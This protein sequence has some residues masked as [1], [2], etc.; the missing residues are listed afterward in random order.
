MNSSCFK[1]SIQNINFCALRLPPKDDLVASA[2]LLY[3]GL[4]NSITNLWVNCGI[5]PCSALVFLPDRLEHL[6][7]NSIVYDIDWDPSSPMVVAKAR[8]LLE[9]GFKSGHLNDSEKSEFI[10]ST[11]PSEVTIFDLLPK[12]LTYLNMPLD[13]P[14][15]PGLEAFSRLP[16]FLDSLIFASRYALPPE[17]LRYIPM[18][19][20]YR[21]DL[22]VASMDLEAMR[23]LPRRMNYGNIVSLSP[24][25]DDSEELARAVPHAHSISIGSKKYNAYVERPFKAWVDLENKRQ[26][27]VLSEDVEAL[28]E[29]LRP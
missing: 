10:A 7:L 6:W 21:L 20:L 9:L 16:K 2:G 1:S 8:H 17:A 14:I 15:Q 26:A 28:K 4:P 5:F 12:T 27:A 18:E 3:H 24:L 29:L 13:C 25:P 11:F 19:N 23:R 22:Y